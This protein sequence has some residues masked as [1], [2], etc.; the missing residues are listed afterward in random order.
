MQ[1]LETR[2]GAGCCAL[3]EK[4]PPPHPSITVN[5]QCVTDD[6]DR[7][8]ALLPGPLQ[9][10]LAAP[11]RRADLL[12]VVLDLGRLPAARYPDR[13]EDLAISR[14][15]AMTCKGSLNGLVLLAAITALALSAPCI[16]S[17]QCAIA[18]AA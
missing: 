2:Q 7:L 15:A 9:A 14:S 16:A 12:E 5:E 6:L 13:S 1:L 11:E 4:V 10:A 3:L 17:V 18:Q 8:L